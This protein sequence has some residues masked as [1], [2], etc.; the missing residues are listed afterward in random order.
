MILIFTTP[1]N[2]FCPLVL[3]S[4]SL[5]QTDIGE[6]TVTASSRQ[7]AHFTATLADTKLVF[8][9]SH[10]FPAEKVPQKTIDRFTVYTHGDFRMNWRGLLHGCTKHPPTTPFIFSTLKPMERRL[11]PITRGLM[12]S[13]GKISMPALMSFSPGYTSVFTSRQCLYQLYL[14][15]YEA[16][17]P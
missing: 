8:C 11:K 7:F 9:T 15:I 6:L 4:S 3:C 12:N 14:R 17:Y 13:V 1:A 10:Y 16:V 5:L 2:P